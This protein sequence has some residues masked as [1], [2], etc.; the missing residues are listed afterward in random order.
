[1]H[2]TRVALGFPVLSDL[3]AVSSGYIPSY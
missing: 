2:V 1:L 3:N